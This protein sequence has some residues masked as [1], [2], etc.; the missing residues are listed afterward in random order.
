LYSPGMVVLTLGYFIENNICCVFQ[1][2]N[3]NDPTMPG[4]PYRL[5]R[6]DDRAFVYHLAEPDGR[7]EVALSG[8]ERVRATRKRKEIMEV[9][10]DLTWLANHLPEAQLRQ[11]FTVKTLAPLFEAILYPRTGPYDASGR[12]TEPLEE[13]RRRKERL[14]EISQSMIDV[15]ISVSASLAP[16][17]TNVLARRRR[18]LDGIQALV[19][20]Y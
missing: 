4:R 6:E 12:K 14:V 17:A 9:I 15:M 19:V 7:R 1:N 13:W 20:G 8:S 18:E 2:V 10:K 3:R 16:Q 11:V 5:L